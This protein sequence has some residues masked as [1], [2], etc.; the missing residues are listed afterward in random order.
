LA[1][2]DS[3]GL[4]ETHNELGGHGVAVGDGAD[5]VCAEELAFFL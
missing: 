1:E 5:T 4:A 2:H 3:G